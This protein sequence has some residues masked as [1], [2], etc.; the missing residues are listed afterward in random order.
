VIQ[1]GE[2]IRMKRVFLFFCITIFLFSI[3]C[4]SRTNT[5]LN[6]I[7]EL[8]KKSTFVDYNQGYSFGNSKSARILIVEYSSY[9]CK[10]CRDLHKNISNILKKYIDNGSLLYIYK[11]VDHPKFAT[12]E[13]INR[14][15]APNNLD[16]IENVFSKFDSYSKKSYATVK[17][18]LNLGEKEVPNYEFMNKSISNELTTGN[19]TG[20]PTMYING[21]KY[22]KIFTKEEFEKILDSYIN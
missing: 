6:N 18:V 16:D 2:V 17:T 13:K 9:E 12:D 19:I 15:F 1:T 10:D 21:E 4:S 11:P 14:Y 7:N 20:T 22:D 8:E 5:K 3:G